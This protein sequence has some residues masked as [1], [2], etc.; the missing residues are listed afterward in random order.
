MENTN[1]E[2]TVVD[3]NNIEGINVLSVNDVKNE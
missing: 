1:T 3:M 2:E